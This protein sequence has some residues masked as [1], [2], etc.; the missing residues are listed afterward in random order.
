MIST[1]SIK[2]LNPMGHFPITDSEWGSYGY[3]PKEW[4]RCVEIKGF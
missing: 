1:M 4:G 2:Q 3:N